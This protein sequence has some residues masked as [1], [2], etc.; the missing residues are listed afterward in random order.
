MINTCTFYNKSTKY[1]TNFYVKFLSNIYQKTWNHY[2]IRNLKHRVSYKSGF[3][4]KK[5]TRTVQPNNSQKNMFK[6]ILISHLFNSCS[7]FLHFD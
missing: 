2:F 3:L 7:I 6:K 4:R 1:L 5:C